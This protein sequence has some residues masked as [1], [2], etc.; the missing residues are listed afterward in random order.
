MIIVV[1]I[2]IFFC[3]HYYHCC[4]YYHCCYYYINISYIIRLTSS[5]GWLHLYATK[6][7]KLTTMTTTTTT[8]T[9]T[10]IMTT[11]TTTMMMMMMMM[12]AAAEEQTIKVAVVDCRKSFVMQTEQANGSRALNDCFS[13]CQGGWV[14]WVGD[15]GLGFNGA[16]RRRLK[17]HHLAIVVVVVVVLIID[18]LNVSF[19]YLS[20]EPSSSSTL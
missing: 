19:F 2:I 15:G 7:N 5:Q 6:N 3:H 1:I 10:T 11:T 13:E 14:M 4:C 16:G 8:M 20:L 18:Y 9:T 12:T 17:P